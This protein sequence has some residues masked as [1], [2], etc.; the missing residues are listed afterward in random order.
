MI[1]SGPPPPLSTQPVNESTLTLRLNQRLV[2]EVMQVTG[3]HVL[4]SVEGVPIV[5]RMMSMDQSALLAEHRTATFIV[6]DLSGQTIGLQLVRP[7]SEEP[8]PST[9]TPLTKDLAATLLRNLGLPVDQANLYLARALISQGLPVTTDLL[10]ELRAALARVNNQTLTNDEASPLQVPWSQEEAQIAAALKSAGLPISAGTLALA[11][12]DLAPLLQSFAQLRLRLQDFSQ[13][14]LPPRLA[15]LVQKALVVLDSM[16]MD[17]SAPAPTLAEN[18]RQA[19]STISR[20]LEKDLAEMAQR[21]ETSLEQASQSSSGNSLLTLVHL[22]QELA[23]AGPSQLLDEIDRFLETIRFKQFENTPT[24]SVPLKEQWLRL[25]IPLGIPY[26]N[27]DTHPELHSAHLRVSYRSE[28]DQRKID[29]GY[30]RLVIQVD[31]DIENF[32]EVDLSLVNRQ[33]GMWLTASNLQLRDQAQTELPGFKAGLE[34]L[35]FSLQSARCEIGE[36]SPDPGIQSLPE[37]RPY[38]EIDLAV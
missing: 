9:A 36:R 20:S 13:T 31:L 27:P 26:A 2:A 37:V 23:R 30:T 25:D 24:D 12:S 21:G 34:R 5:A 15:E 8:T 19:I 14:Q 6:R 1:I 18:L 35:G 17:W 29:P 38:Q 28:G 7:G 10:A 33:V 3:E 22:R 32:I 16:V 4:I 11:K